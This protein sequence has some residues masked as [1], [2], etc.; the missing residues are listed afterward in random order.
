MIRNIA[1]SLPVD[2]CEE[3]EEEEEEEEVFLFIYLR[4]TV[5]HSNLRLYATSLDV[6]GSIPV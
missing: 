4:H 2:N 5:V 6:A 3:E 1:S